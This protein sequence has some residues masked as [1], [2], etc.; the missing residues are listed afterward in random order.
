M[1]GQTPKPSEAEVSKQTKIAARNQAYGVYKKMSEAA[2]DIELYRHMDTFPV[3]WN[4]ERKIKELL[5]F[6]YGEEH[7]S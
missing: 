6:I 7:V 1:Y 5:D 3:H 4:K 2:I